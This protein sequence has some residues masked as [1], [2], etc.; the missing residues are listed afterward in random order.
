MLTYAL[1]GTMTAPRARPSR[2]SWAGQAGD[3]SHLTRTCA[4]PVTRFPGE[5]M[6]PVRHCTNT[7]GYILSLLAFP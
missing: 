3:L 5:T 6:I 4:R 1:A 7:C 2:H